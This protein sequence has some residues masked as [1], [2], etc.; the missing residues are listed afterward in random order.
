LFYQV[1]PSGDFDHKIRHLALSANGDYLW[2]CGIG[3]D[4][5]VYRAQYMMFKVTGGGAPN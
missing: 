4:N 3:D 2:G 1:D 5:S